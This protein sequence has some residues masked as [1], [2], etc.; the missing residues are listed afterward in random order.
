MV[1]S[2]MIGSDMWS[3]PLIVDSFRRPF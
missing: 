3:A 2:D 1:E